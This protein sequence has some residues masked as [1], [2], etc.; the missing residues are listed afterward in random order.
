MENVK[1]EAKAIGNIQGKFNIPAY[2]RGYRWGTQQVQT[3]LNDLYTAAT[4]DIKK[5][6][7][8]Q[9]VVVL[10]K[11][12]H[13]DLIDGQQRLTTTLILLNYIKRIV[14]IEDDDVFTLTY[15]TRKDTSKFL[16][17]LDENQAETNIDFYH[18]Y[19]ANLAISEWLNKKFPQD[20]RR[21][22]N[23]LFTLNSYMTDYV[24]VIWYEVGEDTD[25]I[26]LFT[27]LNIGKIRLTNAE[28]IRAL[29]LT[30][31]DND[32]SKRQQLEMSIQWD[33][34]EKQL[35]F[36]MHKIEMENFKKY[37]KENKYKA[38]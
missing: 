26:A 28:L 30:S 16:E 23:A 9:P 8:L 22:F 6:Y 10:N 25:P 12:D 34:I 1:L 2:Q 21:Q 11:G 29:F 35:P 19:N 31:A 14:P 4:A 32:I 36:P 38:V 5:F 17:N 13:Y 3:L 27:R 20:K 33:E 18:I 37:K 15:E 24:K 7:C